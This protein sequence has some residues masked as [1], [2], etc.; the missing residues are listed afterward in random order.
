MEIAILHEELNQSSFSAARSCAV[1]L[2]NKFKRTVDIVVPTLGAAVKLFSAMYD[3]E[4][5][6]ILNSVYTENCLWENINA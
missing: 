2:A 1:A 6:I 3:P 5:G 4:S